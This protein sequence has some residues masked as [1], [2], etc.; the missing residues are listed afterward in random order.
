MVERTRK[1]NVLVTG[2]SGFVMTSVCESLR[3]GGINVVAPSSR[4]L[5]FTDINNVREYIKRTGCKVFVHA[6]AYTDVRKARSNFK[7][8]RRVNGEGTKN[9]AIACEEKD[10]MLVETSTNFVFSGNC[11]DREQY[12]KDS[13][14][15]GYGEDS[16][17]P[18]SFTSIEIGDYASSKLL[19]EMYAK[20]Y[21][22][23]LA[24]LRQGYPLGRWDEKDYIFKLIKTA[25]AGYGLFSDQFIN[26][27]DLF[28]VANVMK[29]VITHQYCGIFHMG[30]RDIT[31]P[32]EMG[33]YAV[34]KMGLQ[35]E[36][37]KGSCEEYLMNPKNEVIPQYAVLNTTETQRRLGLEFRSWRESV[38]CYLG[39]S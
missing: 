13:I 5:D 15:V 16:R 38:D 26:P 21:C 7:E 33:K 36:V 19:A 25:N 22:S 3:D 6:G 31:T 34:E 9:V 37:K 10:V 4:D 8:V 11:R 23:K 35:L 30:S 28:D 18:E 12:M 2:G 14:Y 24:I 32:Y 29:E 39:L 17:T 27:A 1:R 20:K